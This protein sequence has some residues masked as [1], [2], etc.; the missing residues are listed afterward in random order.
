MTQVSSTF[1]GTENP[2][3]EGGNW[4]S[5][6]G[7]YGNMQKVSGEAREAATSEDDAA[8]WAGASV[9]DDAFSEVTYGTVNLSAAGFNN[10]GA[11]T[12]IN[13]TTDGDSYTGGMT[14]NG[15]TSWEFYRVDDTGSL[16]FT[17]IGTSNAARANGDVCQLDSTGTQHEVFRNSTSIIGPIT[18]STHASGQ[19]GISAF[20]QN[21]NTLPIT[22]WQ[23]DDGAAGA[24]NPKGP[25][26]MPLHGP[27]GGPV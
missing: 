22:S 27:L 24:A 2:L 13:S 6:I 1:D 7:A 14:V 20:E 9:A 11:S 5:G 4:T 17:M 18:D 19:P 21:A 16:A 25:L 3:S 8:R 10:T 26:G 12:R 23:A 15:A